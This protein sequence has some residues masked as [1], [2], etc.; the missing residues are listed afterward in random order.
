MSA[1]TPTTPAA[2]TPT[3]APTPTPAAPAW[4]T[5]YTFNG[6]GASAGKT[7]LT[8][9]QLADTG[10]RDVTVKAV[11]EPAGLPITYEGTWSM[12]VPGGRFVEFAHKM[13]IPKTSDYWISYVTIHFTN[14]RGETSWIACLPARDPAAGLRAECDKLRAEVEQDRE[15]ID[16]I[17][18]N[19]ARECKM[20]RDEI[21]G[22][23]AVIDIKSADYEGD[24]ETM[25]AE[26][27]RL[28]KL[29][30]A[31]HEKIKIVVEGNVTLSNEN[32][33]L[34]DEIAQLRE[35]YCAQLAKINSMDTSNIALDNE[36]GALKAKI[37][38]LTSLCELNKHACVAAEAIAD[39][40]KAEVARLKAQ[41]AAV[42]EAVT[43][44]VAAPV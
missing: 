19:H 5:T 13:A 22:L 14:T 33:A 36:N 26:I 6:T 34:K 23:K 39:T 9:T 25:R 31:Q 4:P 44:K 27:A 42:A 3:P 21:G 2:T 35:H 41:L 37:E 16:N 20:L 29:D 24:R 43:I 28:E 7:T 1:T 30:A 11:F 17:K 12:C 10:V 40:S 8:I 18:A 32:D 15:I 38:T